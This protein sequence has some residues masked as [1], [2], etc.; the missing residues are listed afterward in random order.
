MRPPKVVP[1][2]LV[3]CVWPSSDSLEWLCTKVL[4]SFCD[5]TPVV[6]AHWSELPFVYRLLQRCFLPRFGLLF[7]IVVLWVR[8]CIKTV[9]PIKAVPDYC[10]V[11]FHLDVLRVKLPLW[12]SVQA[13][14]G[15]PLSPVH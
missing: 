4:F 15:Q 6:S 2:P 14:A 8:G 1:S 9:G 13:L 10:S 7:Y 5:V 11:I 12:M 3:L